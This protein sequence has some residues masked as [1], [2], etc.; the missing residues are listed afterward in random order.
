MCI[1]AAA[2]KRTASLIQQTN[3]TGI[4]C[5]NTL[6]HAQMHLRD[7][8]CVQSLLMC[9]CGFV[10]FCGVQA[11]FPCV[12]ELCVSYVIQSG[13]NTCI[14]TNKT[15][16]TR[17][18]VVCVCVLG[19]CKFLRVLGYVC[20]PPRCEN[21]YVLC[22]FSSGIFSYYIH[23]FDEVYVHSR[24]KVFVFEMQLAMTMTNSDT[25]NP[26]ETCSQR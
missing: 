25:K 23:I 4:V 18:V 14:Y 15:A 19:V 10:Y 26:N 1:M 11:C 3:S 20:G 24:I 2:H 13:I 8:N 5:A 22:W 7:R 6:T 17:S 12:I 16:Y 9:V 21:E